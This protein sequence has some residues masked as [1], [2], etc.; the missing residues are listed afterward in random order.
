MGAGYKE[1][2]SRNKFAEGYAQALDTE[3]EKNP[4]KREV[5]RGVENFLNEGTT[6][7][8]R[9]GKDK[10]GYDKGVDDAE[11]ALIAKK[12]EIEKE[13]AERKA[14]KELDKRVKESGNR[15]IKK[16]S[17]GAVHRM[18]DGTIMAGA[19]HG[20]K[21]GGRVKK[22]RMDGIAIRGKTRAKER[23]K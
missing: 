11:K 17:G 15:K 12:K 3:L 20:M 14:I 4:V 6:T 19:K 16:A 7:L 9:K 13:K 10:E 2:K 5:K 8:R 22:C 18:P 21:K 23:S 1:D